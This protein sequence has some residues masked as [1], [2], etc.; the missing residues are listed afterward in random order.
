MRVIEAR[1]LPYPELMVDVPAMIGS[2]LRAI[3]VERGY[4]LATVAKGT[5]IS[6]SF[7]AL[8]EGGRSDITITRLMRLTQFYGIH[9]ADV[10]P[11]TRPED[12]TLVRKGEAQHLY[13]PSEKQ[14]VLLLSK[15]VPRAMSPVLTTFEPKGESEQS[16]HDGEEWIFTLRGS[17]A[18]QLDDEEPIILEEGDS[19]HF[20]SGRPHIYRNAGDEDA[21]L[22]SV[23]TPAVF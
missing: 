17:I 23:A 15:H 4:T 21:S 16:S 6:K 7:L 5:K 10:L 19:A 12:E 8:V 20:N 2:R 18:L 11:G 1:K 14:E 13:S 22:L 3:R 9:I